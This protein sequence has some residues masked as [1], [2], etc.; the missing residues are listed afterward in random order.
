MGLVPK[1]TAYRTSVGGAPT[2]HSGAI[3]RCERNIVRPYWPYYSHMTYFWTGTY[4]RSD[5]Y[6]D[7]Y[8]YSDIQNALDL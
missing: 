2:V 5:T 6:S 7:I 8:M 1:L 3:L 4:M